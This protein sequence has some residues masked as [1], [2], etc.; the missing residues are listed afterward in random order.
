MSSVRNKYYNYYIFQWI[1]R[2]FTSSLVGVT[3]FYGVIDISLAQSTP[4]NGITIPSNTQERIDETITKPLESLPSIPEFPTQSPLQAP[5]TPQF[6]QNNTPTGEK[7]LIKKIEI[8]DNT[9]LKN[10]IKQ[11]V[12]QYEQKQEISFE[13]LI[14]LRTA[15]TELYINKGYITSGAF[16]LNNQL[17]ESGIVQIQVVEGKLE[18]IEIKGLQRLEEIYVRSRLKIA[19]NAPL[20]QKRIEDA[21]QLLQIDPIIERVNAE[22][23]SGSSPGLNILRVE[24]KE[25]P[26]FH[27]GVVIANNQSPSIGSVQG[28]VF[29]VH[30]NFTGFGDQLGLEYGLT[31][32]LNIYNIS[33]KLPINARNGTFNIRYSNNNSKII[34]DDFDDLGIRSDSETLSF[35]FRQPLVRKL[36]TELA[37]GI[38]FDLRRSQTFL[39]DDIPFSFSEGAENGESRVSVIRF[40][41]DWIHRSSTQ[42]LAARSQFSFGIDAFDATV[43][44]TGTDGRFFSWLGQFQWVQQ[45]SKR[46]LLLTRIDA[47]FTPDSLLSLEKFS[48]GG[49]NTVRGYRQNQLVSD[50]GIL[51]VVELRIPLS[52]NPTNLQLTPFFEMGSGWNNRGDNPDPNLIASLGLGMEWQVFR[53][54]DVRLDYGIPLFEVKDKGNS[55]QDNGFY[56]SLQ[57]Q[58]F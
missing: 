1:I 5:T 38:G 39:L 10:E 46:A 16:I 28:S 21:L 3:F 2:I 15:I 57:Y 8:L 11:L 41:Q 55:L 47:Q 43:N 36:Q 40:Y 27:T 24:L 48:I 58:P 31:E 37:I 18:A 26:A 53:G 33:Y 22:L 25:A 6:N 32:G 42:V 7:F 50:N 29:V 17:I 14:N 34:E 12:Q 44:N 30:D 49:V 23:V 56:F 54:L 4:P 52:S 9:I 19:T 51:G 35:S 13:D 20:N 45:V